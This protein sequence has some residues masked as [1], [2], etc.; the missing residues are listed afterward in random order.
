MC[1]AKPANSPAA[2]TSHN[3]T[4][5][6]PPLRKQQ[7]TLSR[8]RHSGLP[9]VTH[10][11]DTSPMRCCM[12]SCA[13]GAQAIGYRRSADTHRHKP[14]QQAAQAR[15]AELQSPH[16]TQYLCSVH[17]R[18]VKPSLA[19]LAPLEH[20]HPR[21]ASTTSFR[22][23]TDKRR[24]PWREDGSQVVDARFR[25]RRCALARA[26]AHALTRTLARAH[27]AIRWRRWR[28]ERGRR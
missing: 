22:K 16:S 8:T 2:N 27:H 4:N 20:R 5:R 14:L 11:R 28:Q 15:V 26:L 1:A 19:P 10:T 24:E 23:S 18:T 9:V 7:P 13:R 17:G 3:I 12:Y 21:H 6:C 25:Q